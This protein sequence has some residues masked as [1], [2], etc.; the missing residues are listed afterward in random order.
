MPCGGVRRTIG[1]ERAFR[2]C[3]TQNQMQIRT[4]VPP[5]RKGRDARSLGEDGDPVPLVMYNNIIEVSCAVQREVWY[6]WEARWV[7]GRTYF[8][9]RACVSTKITAL[10]SSFFPGH[11][12]TM[13]LTLDH[14]VID[15]IDPTRSLSIQTRILHPCR[16]AKSSQPSSHPDATAVCGTSPSCRQHQAASRPPAKGRK[17]SCICNPRAILT[18]CLGPS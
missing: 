17:M 18:G 1:A 11:S 4:A 14:Y 7:M 6:A 10:C 16:I 2:R 9:L 8:S 13:F 5:G 12:T 15:S 3:K